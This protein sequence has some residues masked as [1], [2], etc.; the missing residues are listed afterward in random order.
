MDPIPFLSC[1][2]YFSHYDYYLFS[3][4]TLPLFN[5]S[6]PVLPD[7]PILLMVPFYSHHAFIFSIS[8][9]C[10]LSHP[11]YISSLSCL[12][13][14]PPSCPF[15]SCLCSSPILPMMFS[16]SIPW[17]LYYS[18]LAY[19]ASSPLFSP[20]PTIV[21]SLSC[22]CFHPILFLLP[23]SPVCV[24]SYTAFFCSLSRQLFPNFLP[25]I[26]LNSLTITTILWK[27]CI[28]GHTV[29]YTRCIIYWKL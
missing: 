21:P 29:V 23:P 24:F 1:L 8:C 27:S 15:P 3:L 20:C 5:G 19:V 22:L 18:P 6:L 7:L 26:V 14:H 2:C 11:A 25:T 10:S 13:P 17:S 16:L 4:H 12:C 28:F 9:L